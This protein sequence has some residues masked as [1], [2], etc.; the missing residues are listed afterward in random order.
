MNRRDTREM[1][2]SRFRKLPAAIRFSTA[3]PCCE[4]EDR[5]EGEGE[6]ELGF[7]RLAEHLRNV[8]HDEDETAGEDARHA[9]E[10]VE[11]GEH[12]VRDVPWLPI[13]EDVRR[14]VR[15]RATVPIHLRVEFAR[16]RV[17]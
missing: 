7:Q 5:N 9:R 6:L 4:R 3:S 14:P 10:V 11:K 8:F 17:V 1:G 2:V 12:A 15:S 13:P 16:K